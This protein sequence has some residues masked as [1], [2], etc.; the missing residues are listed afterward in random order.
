MAL[1]SSLDL[2][3]R[4]GEIQIAAAREPVVITHH[5]KPRAVMLSVDEYI[6]LKERA[7]EPVP[8][9]VRAKRA[10]TVRLDDDP[11][12]YDVSDLGAAARRMA[13]DALSGRAAE[14]VE[15]ELARVRRRFGRR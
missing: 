12:G 3:K 2:Q 4:T 11:L 9:E 1:F 8:T 13:E 10:V 14:A 6:R 7:G 5:G 15:A